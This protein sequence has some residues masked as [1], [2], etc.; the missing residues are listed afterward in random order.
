ML[1]N[2]QKKETSE[3]IQ[4]EYFCY[5]S[6]SKPKKLHLRW[7]PKWVLWSSAVE[8]SESKNSDERKR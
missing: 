2:S 7:F 4:F 5:E 1:M 3:T 6:T 8:N